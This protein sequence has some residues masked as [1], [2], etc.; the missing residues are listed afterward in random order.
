MDYH[1]KEFSNLTTKEFFDIA[2]LRTAVFVVE[3]N[4][5]YQEIDDVDE[6]AIH[7]WLQEEQAIVGYIRIIDNGETVSFGRVLINPNYRKQGLGNLLLEKTLN[8]ISEKYPDRPIIIGAQ[9]HL[10]D[11]YGRFGFKEISEVYL[12]DDIPHVK[13]RK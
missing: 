12:E 11:F 2:K 10:T 3:Q 13:M 1:V 4:C 5:P 6:Y 7:T 9:A 8:V